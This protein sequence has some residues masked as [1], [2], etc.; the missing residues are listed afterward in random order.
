ME[1]EKYYSMGEIKRN[2]WLLNKYGKPMYNKTNISKRLE[3]LGVKSKR[4]KCTPFA[5]QVKGSVITKH[6]NDTQ[7]RIEKTSA[8]Y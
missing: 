4:Q 8:G 1:A 2:G 3:E 7:K 5:Y 6:N